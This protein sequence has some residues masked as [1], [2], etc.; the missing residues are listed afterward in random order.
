MVNHGANGNPI[1]TW[2]VYVALTQRFLASKRCLWP[3]GHYSTVT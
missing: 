1:L 2:R 3:T